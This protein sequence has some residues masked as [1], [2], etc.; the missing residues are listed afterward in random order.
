MSETC[1]GSADPRLRAS[2]L[3]AVA[4]RLPA[5]A[6]R[7]GE[8][9]VCHRVLSVRRSGRQVVILEKGDALW[10]IGAVSEVDIVASVRRVR[11]E[12]RTLDMTCPAVRSLSLFAALL[13]AGAARLAAWSAPMRRQL[14][15]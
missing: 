4:H 1:N 6:H 12:G 8:W 11:V 5:V 14:G 7:A 2:R 9:L 15:R 3:P 13:G 10:T